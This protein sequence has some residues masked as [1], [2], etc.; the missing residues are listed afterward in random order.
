MASLYEQMSP[1]APA[2]AAGSPEYQKGIV[3]NAKAT[4]QPQYKRAIMQARQG[5][6]NRGLSRSGIAL[7]TEGDIGQQY[8]GELGRVAGEAATRSAD[9]A[10]QNRRRLEERGWQE[11]DLAK[12]MEERKRAMEAE[13]ETADADRWANLIGA[14]TGGAGTALGYYLSR[15]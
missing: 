11:T 2:P 10:E 1:S 13:R 14:A 15:K 9:L 8:R 12:A 3:E 5:L 4:L 6:Q 7:A